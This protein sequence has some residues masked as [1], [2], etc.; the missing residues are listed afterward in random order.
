M[1]FYTWKFQV[2]QGWGKGEINGEDSGV[3]HETE[4]WERPRRNLV[5]IPSGPSCWSPLSFHSCHLLR[6][7]CPLCTLYGPDFVSDTG[8]EG[9]SRLFK[10]HNFHG[11][12]EKEV[13]RERRKVGEM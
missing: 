1:S 12:H 8:D 7:T 6:S 4:P 11:V 9:V 2:E 13:R 3:A 5:L 10:G